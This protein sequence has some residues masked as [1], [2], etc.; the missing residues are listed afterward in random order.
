MRVRPALILAALLLVPGT[1][2]CD[3][4]AGR[5][6]VSIAA[7]P[8]VTSTVAAPPP[9]VPR[10]APTRTYPVGLRLLGLSR[11]GRSLPTAVWFPAVDIAGTGVAPGRF[12]LVL[13]SHGLLA[14]PGDYTALL[15][16]WA[17]AGFVVAAPAY[18]HTART[19]GDF[20]LPD[21]LNQPADASAVI[22]EVLATSGLREHIDPRRV[23]AAGHSAGALTTVGLF[24]T[25]RDPR[26]RAGIVLAGSALG[27]GSRFTGPPAPMLFVHGDRDPLIS[28]TAGR[29][30]FGELGWPKAFLTVTDQTHT[31]P[32]V[33]PSA[34][35][36]ALV[37]STTLDFLRYALYGDA[38][39]GRRLAGV[40][41]LEDRLC[42][43]SEC[44]R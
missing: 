5:L 43:V 3:R 37:A 7:P 1:A 41:D 25:A 17:A 13:F 38:R 21:V 28:Y 39:A 27:F 29:R 22:T 2:G 35:G 30:L 15:Y 44:G 18:P 42:E 33:R 10:A 20:E 12:P 4:S 31:A 9:L 14:A 11:G 6:A 19:T 36:F 26:L 40:H 8:V 16:R 32:Y 23:G 34:S 24:T